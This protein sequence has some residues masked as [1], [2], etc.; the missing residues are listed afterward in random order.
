MAEVIHQIIER[1][2]PDGYKEAIATARD[3]ETGEMNTT[4]TEWYYD[5]DRGVRVDYAISD[6]LK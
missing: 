2:C 3:S 5:S 4:R 6:L 1:E